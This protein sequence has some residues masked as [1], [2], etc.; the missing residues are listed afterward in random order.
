MS[1]WGKDPT[2]YQIDLTK[3]RLVSTAANGQQIRAFQYALSRLAADPDVAQ[4]LVF[5]PGPLREDSDIIPDLVDVYRRG[6]G[7]VA[8]VVGGLKVYSE[9]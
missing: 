9:G 8:K 2:G 4:S 3:D 6:M 5:K 1:S 7:E